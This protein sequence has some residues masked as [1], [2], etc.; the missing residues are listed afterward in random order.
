MSLS[1]RSRP[2]FFSIDHFLFKYWNIFCLARHSNGSF[3]IQTQLLPFVADFSCKVACPFSHHNLDATCANSMAMFYEFN[4]VGKA[5]IFL[6]WCFGLPSIRIGMNNNAHR[7]VF[8]ES[9][10]TFM[11]GSVIAPIPVEVVAKNSRLS[12]S[13]NLIEQIFIN[14]LLI[15]CRR[16]FHHVF[17]K[18]CRCPGYNPAL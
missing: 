3:K 17:V 7:Y 13:L 16:Y 8:R 10:G 15:I 4:G 14:C 1:V 11:K 18:F 5:G 9:A 6:T 12:T 2:R